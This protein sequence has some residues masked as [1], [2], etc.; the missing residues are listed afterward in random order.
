M[1]TGRPENFQGQ[2]RWNDVWIVGARNFS[3]TLL[4]T[5]LLQIPDKQM[6]SSYFTK[7]LE[8]KDRNSG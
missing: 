3:C 1:E 4:H 7:V 6:T 8:L 2:R 5:V